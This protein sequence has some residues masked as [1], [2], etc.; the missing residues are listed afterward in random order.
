MQKIHLTD[1]IQIEDRQVCVLQTTEDSDQ[2]K[3]VEE[4][5]YA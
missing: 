5:A 4:C 3:K 2:E 1:P